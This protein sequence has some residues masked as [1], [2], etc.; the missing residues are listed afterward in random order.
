M[1]TALGTA[2]EV[3]VGIDVGISLCARV[4]D[5]TPSGLIPPADQK[6]WY[7]AD[8]GVTLISG[9]ISAW[10]NLWSNGDLSQGTAGNRT[11]FEAAGLGGQP[12]SCNDDGNRNLLG[13]LTS[14]TAI[15]ARPYVW[16]Y[17]SGQGPFSIAQYIF[18]L[19]GA[20]GTCR[21]YAGTYALAANWSFVRDEGASSE[22]SISTPAD[23]SPHLFEIGFTAVAEQAAVVSGANCSTGV[24]TGTP[25]TTMASVGV[26]STTTGTSRCPS[27]VAEIVVSASEPSDA[28]KTA[29]R[30][31]FTERYGSI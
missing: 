9:R 22:T 23:T 26:H 2:L 5:S 30:D 4:R 19:Q 24:L 20:A 17:A 1:G 8:Q 29:M 27:R 11:L 3:D 14:A 10:S 16:I 13:T 21:L 12:C 25:S 18:F 15:G 6:A 28:I 7:R 31:Y